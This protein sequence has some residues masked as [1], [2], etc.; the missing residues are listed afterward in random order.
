LRNWLTELSTGACTHAEALLARSS[1][2]TMRVMGGWQL[3]TA[4]SRRSRATGLSTLQLPATIRSPVAYRCRGRMP[5]SL[6]RPRPECS[7]MCRCADA[8]ATEICC[9]LRPM[10]QCQGQTRAERRLHEGAREQSQVSFHGDP[11]LSSLLTLFSL[12]GRV[13][14]VKPATFALQ[15]GERK[16]L[17]VRV[18]SEEDSER[19]NDNR[20][21]R[22]SERNSE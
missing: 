18:I 6:W 8:Q 12:T 22:E 13:A 16:A 4:A 2:P 15:S 3:C 7:V 9:G 19:D 11:I 14:G 5:C 17:Q 10:Q 20:S 21:E 1:A